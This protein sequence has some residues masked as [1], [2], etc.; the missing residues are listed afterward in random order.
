MNTLADD[1]ATLA[2]QERTA[3]EAQALYQFFKKHPELDMQAN[4]N[5]LR[6][7]HHGEEM[8]LDTLE[9]SAA[10]LRTLLGH[11]SYEAIEQAK[12]REIEQAEESRK[13]EKGRLIQEIAGRL[14]GAGASS[15]AIE[16]EILNRYAHMTN[17]ELQTKLDFLNEA[18]RLR[19]MTISELRREA[20][21]NRVQ[22][23]APELP[24]E[25]TPERIKAMKAP[26]LRKLMEHY[27]SG[28]IDERLGVQPTRKL[29]ISIGVK[30]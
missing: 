19:G 7:H 5:L 14:K 25:Y 13:K 18:N 22:P 6:Q 28:K 16:G 24:A 2:A 17:T 26:E 15:L 4:E 10:H 27:G 11:K 12:Q 3:R 21:A 23:Q 1:R 20:R 9:E 29:G 30:P 8:K